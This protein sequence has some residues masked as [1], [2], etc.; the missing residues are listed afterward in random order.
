MK[1]C[2]AC[3]IRK[4]LE[5]FYRDRKEKDG[6]GYTCKKCDTPRK[7]EQNLRKKGWSIEKKKKAFRIQKGRCAICGKKLKSWTTAH[8]DHNHLN[9]K[10]RGLLCMPCNLRLPFFECPYNYP[11]YYRYLEKYEESMGKS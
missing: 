10:S 9:G 3:K 7:Y 5:E 2:S 11:E 6:R 8:A 1:K 4:T